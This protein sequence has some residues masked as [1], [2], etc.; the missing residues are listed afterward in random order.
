MRGTRWLTEDRCDGTVTR[1][2]QGVVV[3][4]NLR[5]RERIRVEKLDAVGAQI[6][7]W[8]APSVRGERHECYAITEENAGSDVDS[9][10]AEMPRSAA[11]ATNSTSPSRVCAITGPDAYST[12]SAISASACSSRCRMTGW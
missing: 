1:V 4:E 2:T 9:I 10:Q 7:R 8:I 3:V 11:R 6:E 12:V 5:T